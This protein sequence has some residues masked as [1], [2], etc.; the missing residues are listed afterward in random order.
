MPESIL[1]L[2][3]C[4]VDTALMRALLYDRQKLITHIK[5][6]PKV[7]DALHQQAER[8]GSSR[9]VIAMV[10]NDKHLFS[11]P[12]LKP[13]DQ[14]VLRCEE[15]G[16]LFVVYRHRKLASQYLIVLDPACDGWLYGNLRAAGLQPQA[17]QLPE[18]LNDFLGFTK[19]IRAEE[20]PEIV[21]LLKALRTSA[22]PAYARLAAFVTERLGEAGQAG[23]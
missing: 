20:Q 19:S 5:G 3:E 17:Y 11:I 12:K 4:H 13:F 7:G 14:V 16:C 9:V 8:Y 18:L 21:S 23:W 2:P 1:F 10:D 15:P 22:P 6:A